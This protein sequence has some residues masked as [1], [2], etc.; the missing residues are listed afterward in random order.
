M[1]QLGR[2][3]VP[4]DLMTFRHEDEQPSVFLLR[5]DRR[6]TM[7][8]VFNWTDAPRSHSFLGGISVFPR[9]PFRG[10]GCSRSQQPRCFSEESLE[11]RE[12]SPHSVRLIKV[13]DTAMPAGSPSLTINAPSSAEVAKPVTASVSCDPDGV[14][15]F[16][17]H[18]DFGDG[19]SAEG[20]QATHTYTMAGTYSI[21]ISAEGADGIPANRTVS[22]GVT[23]AV[24][25]RYHLMKN[26]RYIEPVGQ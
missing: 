14:P 16:S 21:K 23:G 25:S 13:V 7:L 18:W 9:A 15:A 12:Q 22:I 4:L 20:P 19:T 26:R 5:Q 17:Y 2:A 6:Q 24:D 11:L 10:V 3:S 8:A 1:A